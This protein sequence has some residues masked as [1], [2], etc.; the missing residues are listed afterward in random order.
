MVLTGAETA[1]AFPEPFQAEPLE[2]LRTTQLLAC[3]GSIDSGRYREAN[4]FRT[5]P[6]MGWEEARIALNRCAV[7]LRDTKPATYVALAAFA[8]TATGFE[9]FAGRRGDHAVKLREE[10]AAARIRLQMAFDPAWR[11]A[12]ATASGSL[13]PC[14]STAP[15]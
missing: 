2:V 3:S 4:K 11:M 7:V 5:L 1:H 13:G 9:G 15:I 14:R 6:E 12:P 10:L 8:L